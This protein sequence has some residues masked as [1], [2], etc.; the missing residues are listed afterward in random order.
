MSLIFMMGVDLN[1]YF[2]E[3]NP[4]VFYCGRPVQLVDATWIDFLKEKAKKNSRKRARI[5]LHASPE[6]LLHEMLIVLH[7]S[8]YVRPHTHVNRAES[9]HMVEGMIDVVIF[10]DKGDIRHRI[11]LDSKN[12]LQT[13]YRLAEPLF[14]SVLVRSEWAVFYELTTGPFVRE[15]MQ[16]AKWSPP[17]NEPEK[18]VTYLQNLKD[19][20]LDVPPSLSEDLLKKYPDIKR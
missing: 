14:H 7:K 5:C 6:S 16:Y 3:I 15:A 12:S 19:R 11:V 9:F 10:D 4:E 13:H 8:N 1:P 18:I 20:L 17:D 2:K